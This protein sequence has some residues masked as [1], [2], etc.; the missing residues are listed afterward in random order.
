M[1]ILVAIDGS[2]QSLKA[3]DVAAQTAKAFGSAEVA[4]ITVVFQEPIY[5][6]AAMPAPLMKNIYDTQAELMEKEQEHSKML[7]DYVTEK[8][9]EIDIK[10]NNIVAVGYPSEEI[11]KEADSGKYDLLVMGCRGLT[12][13]TKRVFMGSVTEKVIHHTKINVLVVK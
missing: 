8:F 2:E 6:M 10:T 4:L 11:L 13:L 7:L 12:S 5:N 3:A 9:T 1:R